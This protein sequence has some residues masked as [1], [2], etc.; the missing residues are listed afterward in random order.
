[1]SPSWQYTSMD[2]GKTPLRLSHDSSISRAPP[3]L[4]RNSWDS[5]W[6][7][8]SDNLKIQISWQLQSRGPS[9][10]ALRVCRQLEV[11]PKKQ[12]KRT[13]KSIRRVAWHSM[14]RSRSRTIECQIS[15]PGLLRLKIQNR[16]HQQY[17]GAFKKGW[18]RSRRSPQRGSWPQG[19]AAPCLRS[20][21]KP[22][23]RRIKALQRS[24]TLSIMELSWLRALKRP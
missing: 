21:A 1:M 7:Q 17:L 14:D 15:W 4:S 8:L 19:L 24:P 23:L 18:A 5:L 16:R 13:G 22:Q 20:P 6:R 12:A 9:N 2:L 10:L 11:M 3:S